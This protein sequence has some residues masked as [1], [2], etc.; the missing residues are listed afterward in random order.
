MEVKLESV[1]DMYTGEDEIKF[2]VRCIPCKD[3]ISA[4]SLHT[5]MTQ[6]GQ[7]HTDKCPICRRNIDQVEFM[8]AKTAKHWD[9]QEKLAIQEEAQLATRKQDFMNTAQFKQLVQQKTSAE[10]Q[11]TSA[12]KR[13]QQAKEILKGAI[14]RLKAADDKIDEAKQPLNEDRRATE[15]RIKQLRDNRLVKVLSKLSF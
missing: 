9:T 7:A 13:L 6:P 2:P 11:K 1:E 10:K 12:E 4:P 15:A 14:N 3:V 8:S 5:W